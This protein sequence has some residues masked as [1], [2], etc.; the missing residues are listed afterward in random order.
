MSYLRPYRLWIA[1]IVALLVAIVLLNGC[2]SLP[3]D[4]PTTKAVQI[5]SEPAGARIEI[6]DDYVGDAP[7]M[8]WV[9]VTDYAGFDRTTTISAIPVVEGQYFQSKYFVGGNK[10][11]N[12]IFFSMTLA[13]LYSYESEPT[14]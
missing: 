9:P 4:T 11:P 14:E 7:I 10:V 13:P 8:V 12:R 2:S 6:N 5:L 1:I 3:L